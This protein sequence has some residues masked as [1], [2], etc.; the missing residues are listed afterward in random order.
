MSIFNVYSLINILLIVIIVI[1][2][3]VR[4][5][6]DNSLLQMYDITRLFRL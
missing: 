2:E 6:V 4:I 1:L 3:V 5:R